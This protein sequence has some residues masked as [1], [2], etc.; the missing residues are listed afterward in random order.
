[1]D[2]SLEGKTLVISG[3]SRGIGLAIGLRAARDGANVAVLA[4][5]DE[6]HPKLPGTIHTAAAEIEAAGGRSLAIRCDIRDEEQVEA[7]VAQIARTFGGVDICVN[8]A[9]AVRLTG[10]LDTPVKRYDLMHGVNARGTYLLS[11]AC[12][13]H[14]LQAENPHM[15]AISPPLLMEERWFAPHVAYTTAKFGMSMVVLGTAGEFRGRVAANALWPRTAI[16]TDAMAEFSPHMAVGALRSPQIVADAAHTILTSDAKTVTGNFF[17]DDELLALH[18]VT[19]LSAYGPPG[20]AEVDLMADFFVPSLRE[21]RGLPDPSNPYA[22]REAAPGNPLAKQLKPAAARTLHR[23]HEM[24]ARRDFTGLEQLLHPDALFRSP[25]AAKPY[26]SAAA[27]ALVLSTAPV[28]IEE[29]TYHREMATGDGNECTLE[30]SGRIG[31]RQLKGVDLFRFGTDGLITE[32]EVMV[33]P[34]TGV[35]ALKELMASRI[36]E[37]LLTFS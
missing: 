26:R 32:A 20:V 18:G 11:R 22:A 36:G 15:L 4:K 30:F 6:P 5:T 28:A 31:D 16:D 12:L 19:D 13:P 2:R 23:W 1:M 9:S 17:I 24:V 37:R 10:M 35:E 21:L 33:R 3:G 29:F 14:L 34:L 27:V 25:V 7:A 8:N